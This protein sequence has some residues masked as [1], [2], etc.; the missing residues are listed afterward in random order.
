MS[1]MMERLKLMRMEIQ[2]LKSNPIGNA[3]LF[4][5]S[6]LKPKTTETDILN[7]T[8]GHRLFDHST[9]NMKNNFETIPKACS[10]MSTKSSEQ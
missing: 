10:Q 5:S 2:I 9:S 1:E 6:H 4:R 8:F 7:P 3:V